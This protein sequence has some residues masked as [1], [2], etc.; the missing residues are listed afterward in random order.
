[1]ISRR[2]LICSDF[3]PCS[4]HSEDEQYEEL[5]RNDLQIAGIRAAQRKQDTTN[6]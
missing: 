4:K 5:R 1:M 2:C 6:E 3:N